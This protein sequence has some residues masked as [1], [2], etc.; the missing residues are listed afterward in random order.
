MINPKELRSGNYVHK[1]DARYDGNEVK[2]TERLYQISGSDICSIEENGDPTN[3]P[4]PLT[5][6]WLERCGFLQMEYRYY[7]GSI[8]DAFVYKGRRYI[9]RSIELK[10]VDPYYAMEYFPYDQSQNCIPSELRCV[11]Q[12]QN[13]YF[14]LTGIELTI[15]K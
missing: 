3:H 12:L 13:L 10:G 8:T 5:P 11:H 14:A 9:I 7:D 15:K 4:I 1:K 2:I 6:E